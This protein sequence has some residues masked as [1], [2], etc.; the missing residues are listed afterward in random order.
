MKENNEEAPLG[1][2][3]NE[4]S[5]ALNENASGE[6][7]GM[8]TRNNKQIKNDR[9]L[10]IHEDAELVYKRRIEDLRISLKQKIRQRN[11]LLD[12]SPENAQSL[13]LANDFD[14]N[15]YC[16]TDIKLTMDIRNIRIQLTEAEARYN[17]L[18]KKEA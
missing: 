1:A 4:N 18:F 3:L 16:D 6:F 2:E 14:A 17:F 5:D 12:L 8:L 7:Y 15:V 13:K 11:N 10:A 9:A